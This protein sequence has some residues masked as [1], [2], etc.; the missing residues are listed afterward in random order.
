M[1]FQNGFRGQGQVR[2]VRTSRPRVSNKNLAILIPL[3]LLYFFYM[4]VAI[5]VFVGMYYFG[6]MQVRFQWRQYLMPA[7]ALL[8]CA[9]LYGLPHAYTSLRVT[10]FILFI[11]YFCGRFGFRLK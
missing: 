1:S 3:G 9:S 8:A 10:T 2:Q 5:L 7:L 4:P 11:L 6:K